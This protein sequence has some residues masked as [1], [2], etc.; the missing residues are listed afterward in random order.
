M[1]LADTEKI[2]PFNVANRRVYGFPG[3]GL[4]RVQIPSRVYLGDR[5]VN[6]EM[7][8]YPSREGC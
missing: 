7:L 4:S 6:I 3:A 1:I 2:R 8:A 5:D